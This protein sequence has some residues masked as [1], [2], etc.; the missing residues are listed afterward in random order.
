MDQKLGQSRRRR[1]GPTKTTGGHGL[2]T[3]E[4]NSN[5]GLP[6]RR[7]DFRRASCRVEMTQHGLTEWGNGA[8]DLV[9]QRRGEAGQALVVSKIRVCG[10][11]GS[12][13]HR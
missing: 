12:T 9:G 6:G 8:M 7:Y 1:H 11:H 2:G 4:R 10:R 13:A 3:E 5:G